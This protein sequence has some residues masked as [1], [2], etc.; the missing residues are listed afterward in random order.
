MRIFD[1]LW[2][3]IT[4]VVGIFLIVYN[5]DVEDGGKGLIV[6]GGFL[7]VLGILNSIAVLIEINREQK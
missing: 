4:I 2:H 1:K 6:L 3:L 7:V 5:N